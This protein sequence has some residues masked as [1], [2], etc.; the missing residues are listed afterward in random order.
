MTMRPSSITSWSALS[1]SSGGCHRRRSEPVDRQ[2]EID[3]EQKEHAGRMRQPGRAQEDDRTCD[4]DLKVRA[5]KID[6]NREH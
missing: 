5:L 2:Y 3:V 1:E 4:V 6:L